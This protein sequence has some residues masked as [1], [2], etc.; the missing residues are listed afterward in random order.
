MKVWHSCIRHPLVDAISSA[1]ALSLASKREEGPPLPPEGE[2]EA[3][4]DGG[5]EA[6]W[7]W[8]WKGAGC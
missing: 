5:A 8:W 2:G 7:S 3:A 4:E 1:K 6:S